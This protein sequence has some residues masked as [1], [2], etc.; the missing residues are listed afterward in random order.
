[1]ITTVIYNLDH[2]NIEMKLRDGKAMEKERARDGK[3][4]DSLALTRH[5]QHG[6]DLKKR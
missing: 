2:L 6:S 5:T 1:M 4:E 3:R